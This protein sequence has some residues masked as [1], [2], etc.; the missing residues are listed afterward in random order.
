VGLGSR[1]LRPFAALGTLVAV[2]WY[3]RIF[4][5]FRIPPRGRGGHLVAVPL[6]LVADAYAGLIMLRASIRYRTLLL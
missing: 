3:V 1:R 6:G 4:R 2:A 5:R